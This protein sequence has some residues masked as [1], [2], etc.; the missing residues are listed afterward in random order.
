MCYM[1]YLLQYLCQVSAQFLVG[2]RWQIFNPALCRARSKLRAGSTNKKDTVIV[3]RDLSEMTGAEAS[4]RSCPQQARRIPRHASASGYRPV[5][6]HR[7]E[8]R[9]SAIRINYWSHMENAG[10]NPLVYPAIK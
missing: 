5:H 6:S 1:C 4:G 2:L 7:S 10:L 3:Q 8:C 9:M